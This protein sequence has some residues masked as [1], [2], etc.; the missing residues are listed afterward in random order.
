MSQEYVLEERE[1]DTFRLLSNN[2]EWHNG[3]LTPAISSDFHF[4]FN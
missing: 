3:R 4:S 2:W 1:R